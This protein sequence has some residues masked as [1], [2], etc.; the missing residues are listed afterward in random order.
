MKRTLFPTHTIFHKA[1]MLFTFFILIATNSF[2][3]SGEKWATGGNNV[4]AGDIFGTTTNFPLLF[5]TN[6]TQKMSL[7]ANT[8]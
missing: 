3:Q 2:S 6:N 7:G 5:H 1:V 4:G 8:D